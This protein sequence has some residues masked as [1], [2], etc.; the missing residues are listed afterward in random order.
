MKLGIVTDEITR[1]LDEALSRAEAWG[2]R[3]FEL[4]E[5]GERRFPYFTAE[6]TATVEAAVRDGARITAVS[7]GLFKGY[8]EDAAQV[9]REIDEVLP[10]AVEAA[11]R[12]EAPLLIL[13]GFQREPNAP[14]AQRLQVLRAFEAAVERAAAAG[15][16]VAFENEPDFWIDDPAGS[17]V[18]LDELDHPAAGLNWDPANLHWSG[19]EPE[20]D[21]FQTILPRLFN[22]HVKDF[23]PDDPDVPW[24]PV[25]QGTTPWPDLLGWITEESALEHV[26][27][28]THCEPLIPNTEAGLDYVR[29]VLG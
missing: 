13:F 16:R 10:R 20:Y 2:L 26:T 11:L 21:D 12:F 28:E 3:H 9:R 7:P 19:K 18:L 23:T 5:G 24:R 15:L 27:L 4:R 22:V 25:G 14:P 17:M 1:D 6:E 29:T 8:V